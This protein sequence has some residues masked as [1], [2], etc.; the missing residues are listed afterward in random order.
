MNEIYA[1]SIL[2]VDDE[3]LLCKELS[4]M[5]SREG[6]NIE[7]RYSGEEAVVYLEK[8]RGID[9]V[10]LDIN[11]GAGMNGVDTLRIIKDK[12]KHLQVIMLTGE[13]ELDIALECMRRGAYDYLT[14]PFDK[15][16]FVKKAQGAMEKRKQSQMME[17]NSLNMLAGMAEGV[18]HQVNNRLSEFSAKAGMLILKVEELMETNRAYV[19]GN[20]EVREMVD[21]CMTIAEDIGKN[22]AKTG[23]V[24]KSIAKY[25]ELK[26]RGMFYSTFS[27][28]EALNGALYMFKLNNGL[29]DA[30]VQV[31]IN[32]KDCEVFGNISLIIDAFIGILQNSYESIGIRKFMTKDDKLKSDITIT[33]ENNMNSC[34]VKIKDNGIGIID[35]DKDKIFAPYFTSKPTS[36]PGK[37]TDLYIIKKIIEEDHKGMILFESSYNNGA[38]C[39]VELP[40]AR[41]RDMVLIVD[42]D[43]DNANITAKLLERKGYQTKVI[44]YGKKAI[45]YYKQ[46]RPYCVLLD[47]HLPDMQGDEVLKE[48]LSH[49]PTAKILF[50]TADDEMGDEKAKKRG[51]LGCIYKP[52]EFNDIAE[53]LNKIRE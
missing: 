23:N 2:L 4:K 46:Q 47:M 27:L 34:I 10:I 35:E 7:C 8:N 19:D 9:I 38:T 42:D 14:K 41:E 13:R 28:F 30:P 31:T 20:P 18:T 44:T 33:I 24:I 1:M 50:V 53:K 16:M 37:G 22:V 32:A 36:E 52:S 3:E 11:L 12:F 49:D 15:E 43:W 48:I 45:E 29:D 39:Y 5:L 25:A 21:Y 51:A 6:Y 17:K 26:K 40:L